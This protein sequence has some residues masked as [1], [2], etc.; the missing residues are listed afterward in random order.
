QRRGHGAVV[1]GLVDE[2][3]LEHL[4]KHEVAA[5]P[6][7]LGLPARVVVRGAADDPDH[8]RDVLGREVVEPAPEP[9]LGAGGHAADG[10]VAALPEVDL[11]EVG[12]EDPALVV[13]RLDDQ[14]VQ[15]LIELAAPGLLA[16][17]AEQAAARQLLGQRARALPRLAGL[18]VDPGRARDAAYVDAVVVGEVAILH[19][20]Q[21]VGELL[22]HVLHPDQPALGLLLSVES[23]DARRVQAHGLG[24]AFADQVADRGHLALGQAHFDAARR[25]RAVDVGEAAAGDGPAALVIG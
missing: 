9:V 18:Q 10:L 3:G 16:A 15:D 19:R 8:Q 20:L 25:H 13:A 6:G 11:V 21:R 2:P 12:L 14:R 1:L 4:A 24:L 5:H 22:R 17:D 23:G 7:A